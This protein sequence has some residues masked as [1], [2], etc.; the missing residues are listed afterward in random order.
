VPAK[1]IEFGKGRFVSVLRNSSEQFL[2]R[3][4]YGHQPRRRCVEVKAGGKN[5]RG[6]K[7][8]AMSDWK[9]DETVE[10]WKGKDSLLQKGGRGGSGCGK[11]DLEQLIERQFTQN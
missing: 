10:L 1:E 9:R 7:E 2:L 5:G 11:R 4:D 8:K 3:R 6:E